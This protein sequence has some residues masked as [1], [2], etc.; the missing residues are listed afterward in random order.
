MVRDAMSCRLLLAQERLAERELEASALR[1]RLRDVDPEAAA[2]VPAATPLSPHAGVGWGQ[3]P[4]TPRLPGGAAVLSEKYDI[5]QSPAVLGGAVAPVGAAAEAEALRRRVRELEAVLAADAHAQQLVE[6]KKRL[7]EAQAGFRARDAE[8]RGLEARLQ[9]QGEGSPGRGKEGSG[10]DSEA[11]RAQ[12]EVHQQEL[13]RLREKFVALSQLM[14][15]LKDESM[16]A[17]QKKDETIA[18]LARE[19]DVRPAAGGG[20]KPGAGE[21]PRAPAAEAA[22]EPG[23]GAV[24][25]LRFE[26]AELRDRMASQQEQIAALEEQI[27]RILRSADRPIRLSPTLQSDDA[28]PEPPW[29]AGGAA[30]GGAAVGDAAELR[31]RVAGLEAELRAACTGLAAAKESSAEADAR[32]E[33]LHR[34]IQALQARAPARGAHAAVAV[35]DAGEDGALG[36]ADEAVRLRLEAAALRKALEEVRLAGGR[37]GPPGAALAEF[38]ALS[39]HEKAQALAGLREHTRVLAAELRASEERGLALTRKL[40][41]VKRNAKAYRDGVAAKVPGP[42]GRAPPPPSGRGAGGGGSARGAGLSV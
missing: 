41:L 9:A 3:S 10:G 38:K 12:A 19:H 7:A 1:A 8:V 42:P 5:L 31:E 22:G 39:G 36:A 25:R 28:A 29:A 32:T 27:G 37:A 17:L 21:T 20:D 15:A 16:A 33:R 40:G 23:G 24:A 34:Q 4:R 6:V 2:A 30:V 26:N 14:K 18:Q 13:A 35:R 11:L